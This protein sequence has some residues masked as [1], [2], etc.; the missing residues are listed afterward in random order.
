MRESFWRSMARTSNR[1]SGSKMGIPM[2]GLVE[3]WTDRCWTKP[4][5]ARS[6][7]VSDAA[8]AVSRAKTSRR[9]ATRSTPRYRVWRFAT[10]EL[11]SPLRPTGEPYVAARSR[12]AGMSSCAR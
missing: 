12:S 7:S 3:S 9:T 6:L 10:Y 11:G 4:S 8:P 2:K 5:T 1:T